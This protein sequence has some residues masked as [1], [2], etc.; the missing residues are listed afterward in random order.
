MVTKETNEE[1]S[2][3]KYIPKRRYDFKPF[4]RGLCRNNSHEKWT[5]GFFSYYSDDNLKV[6][7]AGGHYYSYC[8]PYD[9]NEHL[10]GTYES[11]K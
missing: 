1:R 10:L 7:T 6:V 9:G 5:A 3:S 8:I 11:E 4:E 2:W